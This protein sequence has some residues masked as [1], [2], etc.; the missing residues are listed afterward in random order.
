[1]SKTNSN[2]PYFYITRGPF[3]SL[4]D[5]SSHLGCG[6]EFL[7]MMFRYPSKQITSNQMKRNRF[8]RVLPYDCVGMTPKDVGFNT[9]PNELDIDRSS[10]YPT[11]PMTMKDAALFYWIKNG[12]INPNHSRLGSSVLAGC[13]GDDIAEKLYLIIGGNKDKCVVCSDDARFISLTAGYS[14]T[15]GM[16]CSLYN[17]CHSND[18]H[19]SLSH[20]N[21][22]EGFDDSDIGRTLYSCG[23]AFDDRY[24]GI[25]AP[26][27]EDKYIPIIVTPWGEFKS[28]K[29]S[30][31]LAPHEISSHTIRNYCTRDQ[32]KKI[33]RLMINTSSV[34][35]DSDLSK[36]VSD[37][38]FKIK[39]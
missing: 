11:M 17:W 19:V 18:K 10:F 38:G 8:L 1:M 14:N 34:F 4:K 13:Q 28:Y 15:C 2:G 36:R 24:L 25:N 35:N 39:A 26:S 21:S 20:L 23:F 6:H 7:K 37:T 27:V 30:S 22:F 9:Y 16:K 32:N 33:T 5:M 29:T 12:R 3:Y 31:E